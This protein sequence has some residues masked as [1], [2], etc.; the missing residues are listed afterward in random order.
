MALLGAFSV[1]AGTDLLRAAG[2]LLLV[3]IAAAIVNG[4]RIRKTYKD[5]EKKGIPI[6]KHSWIWGHL[7]VMGEVMEMLPSDAHSDYM[8][9]MI[10]EHWK[11]FFP[12]CKSCPPVI[13]L[14]GWPM[15]PRLVICINTALSLQFTTERSLLKARQQK[16][17]LY[18]L[19]KNRDVPSMEGAEFKLWKKRLN[20]GFSNQYITARIPDIIEET[21]D[22]VKI[23]ESKAGVDGSWGNVFQLGEITTGLA[24]DVIFRFFFNKR[25]HEQKKRTEASTAIID[26]MKRMYF[27]V[28]VANFLDFY[29]PWRRFKLWQSY[30]SVTNELSPLIHETVARAN[31]GEAS[32]S[33]IDLIVASLEEER[34]EKMAKGGPQTSGPLV[35]D[36]EM[37]EMAI[38]QLNSFIFAGHDTTAATMCWYLRVLAQYPAILERLR[39]EHDEVLGPDPLEAADRLR[40][41]PNLLNSLPY[42]TAIFKE[43]SRIH[44]NV[45]SMRRGEPGFFLH[46]S[47][48]YKGVAFP[49]ED[50]VIWDGTFAA[51]RDPEIWH[52]ANEFLP[53]RW[54]VTDEADPLYTPKNAWRFFASGPR[55]CLGQH[56]AMVEVKLLIVLVARRFDVECAWDEWDAL[57]KRDTSKKP[58]MI[59]GDRCYQV[60]RD[61]PPHVKDEMPVHVRLR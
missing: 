24:L 55:M 26:I 22:F 49:T 51:H 33:F 2:W 61:G 31:G 17:I 29:S 3:L 43:Q 57:K 56:L 47:G 30:R 11:R 28:N 7:P 40:Q 45:G 12:Q 52:R 32:K 37:T 21:E 39:K 15:T 36:K 25:F 35:L 8:M 14:D 38:G 1:P 42:T 58:P 20:P 5:M 10:Q 53:E 60:G 54:L 9:M 44:T 13:Y 50:F 18:P 41:N 46:G 34:A 48:E 6:M 23:L 27:F 4:Y 19:T 59:W 16:E